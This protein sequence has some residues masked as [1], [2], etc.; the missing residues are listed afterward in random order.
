MYKLSRITGIVTVCF[1]VVSTVIFL[2]AEEVQAARLYF[3][4]P[5][6]TTGVGERFVLNLMIDT[7]G[8][9][10]NAIEGSITVSDERL[11]IVGI[12]DGSSIVTLWVER[13]DFTENAVTFSGVTPGGFDSVL[14]PLA[15]PLQQPGLILSL[16]LEG[17][18]VGEVRIDILSARVLL[19]DGI[20]T[21]ASL[22]KEGL[23]LSIVESS[24]PPSLLEERDR[25]LP[26]PFKPEISQAEGLFDN[27]YFLVFAA[28]DKRSGIDYYEV[29]ERRGKRVEDY[30][31]LVWKR[32]ESPV[33]LSDQRLR[34][35]IY[36]K[37]VDRNG[38][39]RVAV[40]SPSDQ[41]NKNTRAL[42]YGILILLGIFAVLY[43]VRRK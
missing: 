4:F 39:I 26:E 13:P 32:A 36:V 27:K 3:E 9:T 30:S 8:E 25:E 10:I 17:K 31:D 37:A 34:S 41:F 22:S 19:H 15:S 1:I 21:E 40:V 43:F 33:I 38:N 2:G 42:V 12:E 24:S 5:T 6:G 16:I 18:S 11:K 7:E 28:T 29:S 14:T 23:V 35:F 20:G